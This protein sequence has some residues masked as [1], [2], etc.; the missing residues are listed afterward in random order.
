MKDE[1]SFNTKNNICVKLGPVYIKML[2]VDPDP[3]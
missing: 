3:L 1:T 2:D